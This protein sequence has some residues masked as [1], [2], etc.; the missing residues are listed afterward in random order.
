MAGSVGESNAKK[1]DNYRFGSV[2]YLLGYV[3]LQ[4]L[5]QALGEQVED[6][7]TGR[8]HRVLGSILRAKGW[9]NEEQEKAIL[10]EMKTIGK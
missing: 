1:Y 10:A 2:A 9:I 4:Q 8:K 6:N 5:Q 7:V 3:T